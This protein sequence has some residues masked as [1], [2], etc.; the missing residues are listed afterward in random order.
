MRDR[1]QSSPVALVTGASSGIGRCC[2]FRLAQRGCRVFGTTRNDP[3]PV[4]EELRSSLSPSH[5]LEMLQMDVDS[6]SSVAVAIEEIL[7]RAGQVD[8]VVNCAGIG[9]AGAVEETS[10]EEA[11]AILSTNL[12]GVLRVC[13]AALPSMRAQRGGTIVNISS[14]GGR[15][16]LPYQGLYSATKFA[17]EGLTEALR[18]EIRPFGVRAVLIEPGDVRTAF[19]DRRTLVQAFA[20]DSPYRAS[21]DRVLSIVEVDER[22]GAA[23]EAVARL[24]EHVLSVRCPRV[25]YTV[26]PFIQRVAAELKRILPSKGFEWAL[27]RYYRVV[28][29]RG[30]RD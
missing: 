19:T 26:G 30:R 29:P 24:V 20:A 21:M 22:A 16:G 18:M 11:M 17:L 10:A 6:D 5:R 3:Q 13:R 14:I 12:L 15:M 23:P 8:V 9:I 28:T 25:R 1:W 7:R 2:A 4:Q 27:S